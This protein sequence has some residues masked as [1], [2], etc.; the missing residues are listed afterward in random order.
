VLVDGAVAICAL[1]DAIARALA[2]IMPSSP[3]PPLPAIAIAAWLGAIALLVAAARGSLGAARASLG[4]LACT[5]VVAIAAVSARAPRRDLRVTFLDVGQ[6]DAAVI[7]APGGEIWLVDAGGEPGGSQDPATTGPGDALVRF[8]AARG[9]DHVDVAI[10]SHPHPDHYLGLFALAGRVPVGELWSADEEA[11][12]TPSEGSKAREDIPI[13]LSEGP[14][15]P[16]R[17]TFADAQAALAAHGTRIVHPPLGT[18]RTAQ[19]AALVVLAPATD[20]GDGVLAIATADPVRSVND[21]SLVVAIEYAGRRVLFTGDL[22]AEGEAALPA[23]RADVVK[24]PHHGSPTSSTAAL[25]AAT[26]PALAVISCGVAN[27]FGFPSPAVV[28]R[29]RAAGA[30]VLRTDQR[31]AITVEVDTDGRLDVEAYDP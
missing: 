10:V 13:I 4:A 29:W 15:D 24:V 12:L 19:G 30:D 25:V 5:A 9:I 7:E 17:R 6:G 27:H 31:G 11:P 3:A 20:L 22:E 16:S 21:D 1:A 28:A 14:K 26:R 23:T 8:L 2:A 18:A